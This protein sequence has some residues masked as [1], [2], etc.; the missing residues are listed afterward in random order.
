MKELSQSVYPRMSV[1]ASQKTSRYIRSMIFQ[2]S[3]VREHRNPT[4]TTDPKSLRLIWIDCEMTGLDIDND[5]LMEIACMVTEG[6]ENLTIGPN[7]IIH[8]D[9][10]LLANM[11]EWCKTQHGK[12]GLTEAVQQS[13]VTEKVAEKQMLEFLSLHTSPGLCPLAGNSIGRDRQFI[14]K[15]M[16][17]LA[18][19]IHYR[20]VDCITVHIVGVRSCVQ[21][22]QKWMDYPVLKS[23][24]IAAFGFFDPRHSPL[25]RTRPFD[26]DNRIR[27]IKTAV[28][29]HFASCNNI[30][31]LSQIREC[32]GTTVCSPLC[33]VQLLLSLDVGY[34]MSL[35]TPLRKK[36]C[37]ALDDIRESRLQLLYYYNSIFKRNQ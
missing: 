11:N 34:Q 1:Q 36:K 23:I 6:D 26:N 8:Q 7:I 37:T 30:S 3:D 14:E 4:V 27:L 29:I 5:R 31:Q 24:V 10:A 25:F 22:R 33:N 28:F 15:Y 21:A 32:R 18:K 19:H 2:N 16:P 12:T 35:L 17:D 9:D 13:T 20:N